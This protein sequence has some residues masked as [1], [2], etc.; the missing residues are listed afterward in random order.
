MSVTQRY[1]ALRSVTGLSG[2]WLSLAA[3]R[4]TAMRV[5]KAGGALGRHLLQSGAA[6]YSS[7][8]K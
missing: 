6:R 1:G 4:V 7:K 3:R 2:V 8:I 5:S